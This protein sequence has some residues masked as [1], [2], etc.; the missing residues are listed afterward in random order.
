[1]EYKN[2]NYSEGKDKNSYF[3]KLRTSY[4]LSQSDMAVI[5]GVSQS[6]LSKIENGKMLPDFYLLKMLKMEFFQDINEVIDAME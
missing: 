5:L 6:Y 2:R 3:F 4:N 1:M